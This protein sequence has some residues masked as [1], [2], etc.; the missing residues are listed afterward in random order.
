PVVSPPD[1]H[2][3]RLGFGMDLG[4]PSGIALGFVVHPKTDA[5]S[6][7]ASFTENVLSPGGRLSLRMDPF[8]LLPRLPIALY[9]DLQAG[10]AGRGSIPGHS[11]DLP[12]F[13]YEYV[14]FY[15][16]LRLG[17]A[18]N[19]NW[20]FEAGPTYM[21]INTGNFQTLVNNNTSNVKG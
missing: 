20:F 5:L 8:A 6:L 1:A 15:G 14:N 3:W 2:P 7:E 18:K 12:S 13:S 9:A 16:G 10:F 21:A 11:A 19:F 17:R 4:L